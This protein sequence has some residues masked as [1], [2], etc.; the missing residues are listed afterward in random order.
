MITAVI[1]AG[2]L[3][4]RLRSVIPDL[5]KP[6]APVHNRPFLEYLMDYWIA[7][8]V[9]KFIL[10]VGYKSKGIIS[11]F[12]SAYKG[13]PVFYAEEDEPL[14][15][16]GGLVLAARGLTTPFLLLNG[17]TY[18]EVSLKEL[19]YFHKKNHSDCTIVIFRSNEANRYG[20]IAIDGAGKIEKL[21]TA[22]CQVGEFA[23]GGVYMINPLILAA[24]FQPGQ[25]YSLED[26]VIATLIAGK[27]NIFGLEQSG[28]FLDIGIPADYISAQKFF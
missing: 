11:H 6:M 21:K 12:G 26:E 14:G 20:A 17:D 2:G 19:K 23:N 18:F 27:K 10:S 13:V 16:G 4:T 7:Q 25:K 28:K 15:T 8:G 24:S 5:P 9:A 22:K 3:G 1:L